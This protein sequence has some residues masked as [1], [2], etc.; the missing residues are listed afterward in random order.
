MNS[1]RLVAEVFVIVGLA[2]VVGCA[3][4]ADEQVAAIYDLKADPTPENVDRLRRLAANSDPRIRVTAIHALVQLNVPEASALAKEHLNDPDGFVRATAAKLVADIGDPA[5]VPALVE[6]A[7]EDPD[8][9]VRQRAVEALERLGGEPAAAGLVDT[10]LDPA[11]NVRLAAVRAIRHLDPAAAVPELSRLLAEDPN[12]EVRVQAAAALGE[13]GHPEA[14]VA[15]ESAR[16]D[17]NEFVRGAVD[18][19]L[20]ELDAGA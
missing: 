1:P 12:W 10:L 2:L 4:D 5:H 20:R 11:D 13:S 8:K 19:A 9:V 18:K 16:A 14:R 3:P 17:E 15:L 7:R 6:R